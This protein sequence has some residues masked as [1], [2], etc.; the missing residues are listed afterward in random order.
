M[1]PESNDLMELTDDDRLRL[2]EAQ[3]VEGEASMIALRHIAG[4]QPFDKLPDEVSGRMIE[5]YQK[6][7]STN[8][9]GKRDLAILLEQDI[10]W[11]LRQ[12]RTIT[13]NHPNIG[14]VR[15]AVFIHVAM[16]IGIRELLHL[17][18]LWQAVKEN[19]W[20][21]AADALLMSKWPGNEPGEDDKRRILE[22]FRMMRTGLA[23][24][25]WEA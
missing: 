9:V 16:V 18:Y 22:L 4:Y 19:R 8:H 2:N 3:R 24:I 12:L 5:A 7:A 20:E 1:R 10:P 13:L 21:D 17:P 11:Y 25:H 14:S 23:P 15:L 6:I